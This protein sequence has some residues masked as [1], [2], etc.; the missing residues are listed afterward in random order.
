MD[1]HERLRSLERENAIL[2]Q[3]LSI[4]RAQFTAS[5]AAHELP[6]DMVFHQLPIPMVLFAPDGLSVAMN[7]A[8]EQLVAT[9]IDQVVGRYNI[10]N[11]P[12]AQ[13]RGFVAAFEAARRGQI[14]AM[15][16]TPYDTAEAEIEGRVV[17]QQFWA[18]TTYFPIYDHMH[19][20][21]LIGEMNRDVTDW[22]R[23]RDEEQRLTAE[24]YERERRFAAL[25]DQLSIG[26]VVIEESG[27]I[28][29]CNQAIATMLGFERDELIGTIIIHR[30]HPDDRNTDL[31]LW[32][33]LLDGK[34]DSYT[35]EK[36]Y[37]H[38]DGHIVYGRMTCSAVRDK[39]DKITFLVRL[40]EDISA[41]RT[42]EAAVETSRR[43]LQDIINQ[44][45]ALI[46]VK[47]AEGHYLM[48]NERLAAFAGYEPQAMIGKGDDELFAPAL[49]DYYRSF[50]REV[51]RHRRPIQRDDDRWTA[52]GLTAF[53]TIKFPLFD[54]EGKIYGIAGI[55]IDIT[56][57]R[58]MERERERIEQQLR[59]TQRL[60]S[61]G[62]MAGGIAHDF[63]NLLV[64]VLGNVS[65]ALSELPADH[66][67][68]PLLAQIE[69]A[70]LR[71]S[72]LTNQLL[73]YT[74]R[75]QPDMQRLDLSRV[76]E[77]MQ[78]LL[79]SILPRRVDLIVQPSPIPLPIEGNIAQIR[80]VLMNLAINGAEAITGNG[81]VTI[82]T[83]VRDVSADETATMQ[84]GADQ[85]P[86]RYA[87]L[88][89]KDTG[90]G[91]D[92]VTKARIFDPFFSTKFTGRGLGLAAVN[93]IVR[94]H[95]GMLHIDTEPNQGTT[96][97]VFWP[98]TTLSDT[99]STTP[100]ESQPIQAVVEQPL[101]QHEQSALVVD[102]EPDVRMVA[103]RMLRRIGFTVYEAASSAEAQQVLEQ[104]GHQLALALIDLSMPGQTGDEL[105]TEILSRYP[106]LRIILMSGFS[107][108]ELPAHLRASSMVSFLAK[109]F[110]LSSLTTTVTAALSSHAL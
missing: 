84:I 8:N 13:K 73:T 33:E 44:I 68:Y 20:L 43:L 5:L 25:F 18:E 35:V 82:A 96:F 89:V 7:R 87:A 22:V 37:L 2:R 23:I 15:P 92:E 1:I 78:T 47:D 53:T 42:A 98:M 51:L 65:L 79:R 97:T 103:Q 105:A 95:R 49:A 39:E 3:Q 81:T 110:T 66:P 9:P 62:V 77:E 11:D 107:Q 63:N 64:G 69:Q 106:S 85:P 12:A 26:I 17:D 54:H 21:V 50:D 101:V 70:A 94:T 45:P 72:E 76:V 41:Q 58:R 55:A 61:L 27:R 19:R 90:H 71:A 48:V 24:L 6:F 52:D 93:G 104:H 86:G 108:Q 59:E 28:V 88:I 80:Q 30:T 29:D 14:A 83:E 38:K 57:R 67:A 4:L 16:P 36:R 99:I 75:H 60:E 32:E 46:F 40:I 31:L 109:P 102:D 34:R 100:P 91:M 10:Y 74:G 56:E